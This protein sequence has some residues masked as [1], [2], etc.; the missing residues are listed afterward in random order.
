V[1][2]IK[3]AHAQPYPAAAKCAYLV[4]GYRQRSLVGLVLD[5]RAGFFYNA[6]FFTFALILTDFSA[7]RPTMSAGTPALCRRNFLGPAAA[8]PAF[9]RWRRKR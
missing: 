8:R 6:I 7:S 5:G 9:I 4:H 2:K 1:P 3:T